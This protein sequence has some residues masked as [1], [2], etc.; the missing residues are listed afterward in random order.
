MTRKKK[1]TTL[2][3]DGKP[4]SCVSCG[5]PLHRKSEYYCSPSCADAYQ[6]SVG[7]TAPVFLSKWKIRKRKQL[8]DPLIALR[9][10][11]RQKTRDLIRRGVLRRGVCAFCGDLNVVP[12]HE[13]Y[14]D[15]FNVIW[16][17]EQHHEE[18]HDGKIA[19]FGGTVRW[20]PVRLTEVGTEVGYPEE[21]YRL[22]REI[23]ERNATGEGSDL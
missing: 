15:P 11:V 12:H 7:E 23:A 16:L 22:L 5:K 17:C 18:Y 20:D 4:S 1:P 19:L 14:R 13:D 9:Q 3:R 8:E 10:Q 6:K 2:I 21:K